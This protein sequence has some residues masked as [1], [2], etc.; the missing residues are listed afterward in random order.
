MHLKI[1]DLAIAMVTEKR[2]MGLWYFTNSLWAGIVL[3]LLASYGYV[4]WEPHLAMVI[5]FF[6][7]LVV[8]GSKHGIGLYR[9]RS[10]LGEYQHLDV[11]YAEAMRYYDLQHWDDALIR[12]YE[13]LKLGIDHK[14]ALFH[15]A[16]CNEELS[17]WGEVHR[18]TE[19]YLEL[20]GSDA[21]IEA[22]LV[23]AEDILG[24]KARQ[25]K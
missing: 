15:A 24:I 6:V 12:L 22:L 2:W 23:K 1:R 10:R 17:K 8:Y 7:P 5:G 9:Y 21:E 4:F 16:R 14:R 13:V 3:Y 25:S 19:K 11:R 18:L 20:H